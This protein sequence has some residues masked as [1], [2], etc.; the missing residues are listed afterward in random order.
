MRATDR[1]ESF[2]DHVA[3]C[4]GG[5]M[6]AVRKVGGIGP[7]PF[8]GGDRHGGFH[9]YEIVEVDAA[10]GADHFIDRRDVAFAVG[11]GPSGGADAE[12]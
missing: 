11:A 10:I 2:E 6:D 7:I 1:L 8:P 4:G 3:G 5:R 12:K 9:V